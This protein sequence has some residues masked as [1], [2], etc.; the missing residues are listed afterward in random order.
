[1][2]I[3]RDYQGEKEEEKTSPKPNVGG[4]PTFFWLV[5]CE[6]DEEIQKGPKEKQEDKRG[7]GECSVWETKEREGQKGGERGFF[8]PTSKPLKATDRS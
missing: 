7:P 1:M 8:L 3:E 2:S 6:T 5:E 4:M